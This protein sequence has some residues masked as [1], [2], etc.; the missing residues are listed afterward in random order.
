MQA[1]RLHEVLARVVAWHNRHPLAR[2]INAS[3]VHSIGEVLLPFASA[4]ALAAGEAAAPAPAQIGSDTPPALPAW[5]PR[6]APAPVPATAP[7]SDPGEAAQPAAAPGSSPAI[8]PPLAPPV[9]NA[10]DQDDGVELEIDI[11]LHATDSAAVAPDS[12][13]SDEDTAAAA[14]AAPFDPDAA[15][16]APAQ[17]V[18]RPDG[19][20]DAAPATPTVESP[21]TDLVDDRAYG[22][23]AATEA[24]PAQAPDHDAD[25][26]PRP[27][28]GLHRAEATAG[29]AP[30]PRPTG[31]RRLLL[32]LR[33]A[34]TGRQPG[35]PPL[36]AAFSRDFIWPLT[37]KQV[38]RWA[39]RHGQ[40]HPLAP[41][42]WPRRRVETDGQRLS[43]A[44]Q[45]GLT[46]T[47]QLHLLTAAIGVGDRRIRVLM[48]AQGAVIGPRAYSRAR[49]GAATSLLMAGV[50]G[51]GWGLWWPTPVA[52]ADAPALAALAAS[53]PA[54]APASATTS[55]AASAPALGD[56]ASAPTAVA[57]SAVTEVQVAAVV[58]APAASA[59]LAAPALP[60]SASE[61]LLP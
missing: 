15:D 34:I 24:G 25:P 8:D 3:Q 5:R 10:G 23:M 53:A 47:V 22:P 46:H 20:D 16:P 54:S 32:A 58:L 38:A 2:R 40:V 59:A 6:A 43:Q 9:D 42:D 45:K 44:R 31:L 55:A 60:A 35:M 12:S 26:A 4:K 29:P 50:L 1:L 27:S 37:P 21:A 19:Q 61:S 36:Q 39:Q 30:A 51:V 57:A 11:D 13:A 17:G 41:A 49:I 18:D 7:A 14:D 48:D 56:A 28:S 52:D 33:T